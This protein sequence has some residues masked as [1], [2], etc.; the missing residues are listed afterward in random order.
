MWVI[1]H[2]IPGP[3]P[4]IHASHGMKKNPPPDPTDLPRLKVA[5][6]R[7]PQCL[8]VKLLSATNL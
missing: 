5:Q 3:G 2:N 7:Q 4:W 6:R 8:L 1:Y